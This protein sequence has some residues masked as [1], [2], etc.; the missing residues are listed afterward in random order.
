MNTPE[1]L[2]LGITHAWALASQTVI[3]AVT[4]LLLGIGIHSA[5][6]IYV[7]MSLWGL[8]FGGAA[9]LLQTALADAA[10]AMNVVIWNRAIAVGGFFGGLLLDH[11]GAVSFPWASL[12]LG[13]LA[14]TMVAKRHGFSA[15]ARKG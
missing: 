12:V 5:T 13:G 15:E 1:S 3:N 2:P 8:S 6:A 11:F 10:L 4:A 9:T 14:L 7:G